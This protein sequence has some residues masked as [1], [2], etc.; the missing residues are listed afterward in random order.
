MKTSDVKGVALVVKDDLIRS[1]VLAKILQ[2]DTA[3]DLVLLQEVLQLGLRW[4][5]EKGRGGNQIPCMV[6]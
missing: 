6:S 1:G 5:A 2:T 3:L 4:V